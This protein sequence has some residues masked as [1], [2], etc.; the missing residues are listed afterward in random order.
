MRTSVATLVKNIL[1][2]ILLVGLAACSDRGELGGVDETA[3]SDASQNQSQEQE[4]ATEL[5][6]QQQSGQNLYD[7]MCAACHGVD[8]NGQTP[9]F[10]NDITLEAIESTTE[11]SMP[12]GD[13]S[14]CIDDCAADIAAYLMFLFDQRAPQDIPN[15]QENAPQA[16]QAATNV[17]ASIGSSNDRINVTWS[18]QANNEAGFRLSR[19]VNNGSFQAIA[20]LTADT[21]TYQDTNVVV[22][23]NYQYRVVVFN[24]AGES[25][26]V[27]SNLIEL[28]TITSVANAPTELNA[29]QQS[30][31]VS[32]NWQDNSDNEESFE[33]YRRQ[34]AENWSLLTSLAANIRDYVDTT[35]VVG[36]TYQYQI[37]AKNSAGESA[38]SN[39]AE[40][41]VTDN[42]D[43]EFNYCGE[44]AWVSGGTY[45]AGE[46]V[47]NR[48]AIFSCKVAGWCS[49]GSSTDWAYEPG[50]G[51]YWQDAWTKIEDCQA[52][53]TEQPPLAIS[54][55]VAVA[56][57]ANDRIG[58]SWA[59][60]AN[61]ESGFNI[62]R[63]VNNSNYQ[64]AAT[65]NSNTVNYQDSNVAVNNSYQYQVE[66][67]NQYGKARRSSSN[68]VEL[69]EQ[70]TKPSRPTN[71][72]VIASANGVTLNWQD[73]SDNETSFEVYRTEDDVN[74][75]KIRSLSDNSTQYIDLNVSA[76]NTYGYRVTALNNIGES[77]NSNTVHIT[78]NQPGNDG[79]SLFQQHC[80]GCHNDTGGVGGDLFIE[81]VQTRWSNNNF[82]ELQDKITTMPVRDCDNECFDIIAEYIWVDR[83]G[84]A[85][86]DSADVTNARGVR[87][88]KLLT[89]Y[90]Y[91]NTVGDL[92]AVELS[93]E[94]L[95][96]SI[97]DSD[98]KYP[99]RA[100]SGVLLEDR[101]RKYQSL[102][103]S[104]AQ[105]VTLSNIGCNAQ[106]CTTSQLNNIAKSL[107]RRPLS[108]AEQ[109]R[110]NQINSDHGSKDALTALLMS[111]YFLYHIEV[112]QWDAATQSYKLNS[113]EIASMLSFQLWG[114][115][116]N[117]TLLAKADN[118]AFA[119]QQAIADEIDLMLEDPKF[120]SHFIRFVQY[121]TKTYGDTFEKPGLTDSVINAM[122]QE[123]AN[124][125]I[126]LMTVGSASIDELFNPGYTFVNSTLAAH[127]DLTVNA[128]SSMQRVSTDSLRGGILHQGLTQILNSDFAAT[129][130]VRRG[131]MIRENMMCNIM[132]V[133]VGIDPATIDLPE[134][135]ITTRERWD[136]I[137]GPDASNGECWQCHSIMNEPGS[138]FEDYDQTGKHRQQ[139]IAFNDTSVTLAIETAG[140]LRDN[141]GQNALFSYRN[142]R[143]LTEYLAGSDLVRNCMA[144]NLFRFTTG[145]K[146]DSLTDADLTSIQQS[147]RSSGDIK[148]LIKDLLMSNVSIYRLDRD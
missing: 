77:D 95:P 85:L 7:Q 58:V 43:T 98:F 75:L 79:A 136:I 101:V 113:Y 10:I 65:V 97:I 60:N 13:A 55:L 134:H 40:I 73:N 64:L 74:W 27:D 82:I 120:A 103:E 26:A 36:S 135:P 140:V 130:L 20:E 121:Y 125:I 24:Q 145:Y 76:G 33:L 15:E 100:S 90:E 114:T 53:S 66:A 142:S 6:E 138:A 122:Q 78:L 147:F 8:G 127:Y 41:T 94:L 63:K 30:N 111:P 105:Q 81:Q 87:G 47:W 84:F 39:Q 80:A 69:I 52:D 133:P 56:S 71:L 57:A 21:T 70:Q 45:A 83:W 118:N 35:A 12:F 11:M 23:N 132:G 14:R 112:G 129:S 32:L 91:Q 86:D 1:L 116:P 3:D 46:K 144:D 148:L 31:G 16:P 131:K 29:E 34:T 28:T 110:Y 37:S 67:F 49:N 143:E 38:R 5:T 61:N 123:Q 18:G 19:K 48:N 141:S 62:Y 4:I 51:Q 44:Q 88:L 126:H 106:A 59:D 137:T 139:E 50:G 54:S 17:Q 42:S 25:P 92:L 117:A 108:N 68:V 102:A 115:A 93:D 146:N 22:N 2:I 89:P 128:G 99:T 107:F 96:E 9:L 72:S 109:S 124:A 119:N 104:I